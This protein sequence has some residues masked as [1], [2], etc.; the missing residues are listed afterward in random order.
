MTRYLLRR[1][2]M[3]VPLLLIISGVAFLL[4]QLS[5]SD[6]AEVALRVNAIVPTPQAI[7]DMRHELG[8]DA[9][10]WQQYLTWLHRCVHFDLGTTFITRQPVADELARALP[11]TLWLAATTLAMI[12]VISLVLS[13]LCVSAADRWP[14]KLIRA[15][16]F[17]LTAM[18][19]YWL[20]LLLLWL[21]A[22]KWR[23]L[24]VGGID[25]AGAVI[26]PALTLACGYIGTYVRLLRSNMLANRHQP[27]VE[28][29][30]ARGLSE[31]RILWRY[32]LVNALYSPLVALGMSIPKL[33]AGTLIIENIFA[34]PGLGRLCVTAIFERDYPVIQAY[35]L[36]MAVLF[37]VCNFLIDT[38]Q[39]WLDP[40]L[41]RGVVR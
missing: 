24:P 32:V 7:A 39:M 28:Y 8:L 26:L 23:W 21:V 2:L 36:L 29:A 12:V 9:P 10:L 19:G 20:G 13:L 5:P 34:W 1:L 41:R 14:D 25:E 11:A 4:I 40:R 33:I 18:P 37:V 38:L 15:G 16:L 31:R 22:V 6:P 35:V 27:W 3:M 30:R 17:L